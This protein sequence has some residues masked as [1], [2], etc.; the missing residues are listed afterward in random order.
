ME[1]D[2]L[3]D[4]LKAKAEDCPFTRDG[5]PSW[6]AM[7][8]RLTLAENER[9]I[10][11]GRLR[12]G[13]WMRYGIAAAVLL[14]T[15]GGGVLLRVRESVFLTENPASDSAGGT[16]IISKAVTAET[17]AEQAV[18]E[19]SVIGRLIKS[20]RS[21]NVVT[22][23]ESE[24][25]QEQLLSSVSPSRQQARPSRD[26]SFYTPGDRAVAAS[27]VRKQERPE[28][29]VVSADQGTEAVERFRGFDWGDRRRNRRKH[30]WLASVTASASAASRTDNGAA[31]RYSPVTR[32]DAEQM[33]AGIAFS[34]FDV[35]TMNL[36]HKF[37]VSVG[38]HVGK[39][40]TD[41]LRLETGLVYTYMESGA[42]QDGMVRYEYKQRLHYL[43]IPLAVNYSLLYKKNF[44]IYLF[45]GIMAEKALSAE[46]TLRVYNDGIQ[47]SNVPRSL[48]T[49]GVLWSVNAGLG[50]GYDFIDSF[51]IYVAPGVNYYLD[52]D[53]QPLSY[54]TENPLNISVT[55][56]L[57]VKF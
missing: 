19:P 57:R 56:G 31:I 46:G 47:S 20:A 2:R 52:N 23:T 15:V 37:P 45:G 22:A 50:F 11:P 10:V 40:L 3:D 44:D 12:S 30:G 7:E 33:E 4:I 53:R 6:S 36:R 43:G 17:L 41:R 48:S 54:R 14:L 35:E 18:A 49:E 32:F 8:R 55:V 51:G 42:S 9:G 38:M 16:E 29:P 5:I 21:L 26:S 39:Q 27:E 25:L 1:R 13:R 28:S 24:Q 34:N